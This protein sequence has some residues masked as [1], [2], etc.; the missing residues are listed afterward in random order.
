MW[1]GSFFFVTTETVIGS[2]LAV[3]VELELQT[4]DLEKC[5]LHVR[6]FSRFFLNYD[7][8][9]KQELNKTK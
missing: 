5:P 1:S 4:F 9:W 3:L 7:M 6:V 2:H 8:S